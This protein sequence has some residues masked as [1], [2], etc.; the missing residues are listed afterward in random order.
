MEI[1]IEIE[2]EILILRRGAKGELYTYLPLRYPGNQRHRKETQ[3]RIAATSQIGNVDDEA[4]RGA[5]SDL[6]A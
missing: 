3:H 2:I 6:R 5:I 4:G 1:E